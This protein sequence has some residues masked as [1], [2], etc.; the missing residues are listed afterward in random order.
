V[1]V[2]P[3]LQYTVVH[4]QAELSPEDARR[5]GVVSG[6]IVKVSQNGSQLKAKAAVRSGIPEGSVFLATGLRLDSANVFTGSSVEI[7]KP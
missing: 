2:S 7:V 3:S 4:Q 1:E 6:E 5:L